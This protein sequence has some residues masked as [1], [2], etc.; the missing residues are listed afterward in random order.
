MSS[1]V[2]AWNIPSIGVHV[3]VT[4]SQ[5]VINTTTSPPVTIE[6]TEDDG[7]AITTVLTVTA[8]PGL[9]GA[10]I[11]CLDGD[12]FPQDTAEVHQVTAVVF[13]ESY[14]ADQL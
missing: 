9:N 10:N 14:I 2:H 12:A 7:T 13:G 8:V 5:P 4:R 1:T 11:S 3:V 6:L